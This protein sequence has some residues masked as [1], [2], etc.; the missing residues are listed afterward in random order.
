MAEF[1][2]PD[3]GEGLTEA[4]IV[5][6]KV[7]VGDVVAINDIVVEIETAK[8]LVE[9]PSPYAGTVHGAARARGRDRRRRHA[10]HRDR[11][12]SAS[13]AGRSRPLRQPRRSRR[14]ARS[15]CPTPRA[16]GGG[17]G[18]TPGR[19]QQGRPRAPCAG[20]ARGAPRRRPRRRRDPACS[21][22]ARSRP[23]GA[24]ERRRGRR[25]TSRPC[26]RHGRAPPVPPRRRR[27]P[28]AGQAAGA[29][30]RQGPRRRPRHAAPAPARRHRHPRR[31]RRRPP[32]PRRR[33]TKRLPQR[34]RRMTSRGG[35]RETPRA[36]QGRAQDD[37][38][39]DGRLGVHRPARHRVGHRR[40]HPHD[41]ARRA[42]QGPP[43]VPRRQGLAAAGAG[44]GRACSRCGA[45]RRS[46]RPGTSAAQEVVYKHYVNLGIAAATPRGLV[47]P[48]V[49]DAERPLAARAGRRAQPAHRDR[50]RGARPSRPR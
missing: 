38:P 34:P 37:G 31:R 7:K 21:C 4:E 50:P 16:S 20:P 39:G 17:E 29:Q 42:A 25:P 8:S 3:V 10:D 48:N 13:R 46:T 11:R 12:P 47:V 49:K 23:G 41:G 24:V 32:A 27:R 18:E 2:L 22:R 30:A 1:K 26:P 6:W 43:R 14:D 35:E 45:P 9:L 5:T 40:R 36:D 19:P 44:P 28:R 15:T 33:H